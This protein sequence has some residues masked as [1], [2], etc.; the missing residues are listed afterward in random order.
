LKHYIACVV[1]TGL[2]AKAMPVA[3]DL[4]DQPT[5]EAREVGRD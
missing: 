5:F 1:T 2:I 4:D 3:I